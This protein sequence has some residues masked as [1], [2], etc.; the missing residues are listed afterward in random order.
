MNENYDL[1]GRVR[2]LEQRSPWKYGLD[3]LPN[4][5]SFDVEFS[6]TGQVL[7]QTDYTNAS[8]VYKS[9]RF[10]YDDAGRHI[11][12][13]QFDG[14]GAE[15]A[16]SEFE[17][18]EGRRVCTTRDATGVVTGR[19]VDE[20][21]G[22]L[23]TLLGTYDASGRPKRLKSFEYAEGKLSR[24]VSKYYGCDGKFSEQW[25]TSYDSAGRVAETFGLKADGS[26]LGDGRYTY[27]YDDEGRKH[28]ILSYNDLAGPNIPNSIRSFVYQCDEHG[29]WTER[30]E[31]HRF[32]SDCDWTKRITTR[33]LTYYAL[34]DSD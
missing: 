5:E 30:T 7:Q 22:N 16:I 25:I 26:P 21:V 17:R 2:T 31:Y 29:N 9:W 32:R 13:V 11:R 18:A 14:A 28:K 12:T 34:Q 1:K 15:V 8:A 3:N 27:E 4:H 20:F 19:D 24:S 10:I 23:L 33:K 6:P